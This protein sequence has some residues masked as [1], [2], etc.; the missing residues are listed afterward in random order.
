MS[1]GAAKPASAKKKGGCTAPRQLLAKL[2][3]ALV[4]CGDIAL[5]RAPPGPEPTNRLIRLVLVGFDT[6]NAFVLAASALVGLCQVGCSACLSPINFA[7]VKV[8][9]RTLHLNGGHMCQSI[10]AG[11]QSDALHSIVQG[12]VEQL[13]CWTISC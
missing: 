6:P 5:G 11:P 2:L 9:S 4:D 13:L 10:I 3:L 12:G 8:L 1:C 7:F